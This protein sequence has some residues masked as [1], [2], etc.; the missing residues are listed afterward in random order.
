VNKEMHTDVFCHLGDAVR[1]KHP[2]KC[3][4]NGWFLFRDNAPAHQSVLVKDFVA[5]NN[6]ITPE[7]LPYSPDVAAA[8]F[9][10][11]PRLKLT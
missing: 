4:A 3:R 2:Q 10:L 5:K 9:Y 8:D 6:V 11:F 7:H 1:T